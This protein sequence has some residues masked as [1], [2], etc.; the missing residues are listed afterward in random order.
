MLALVPSIEPAMSV[1]RLIFFLS[2]L[3]PL[4]MGGCSAEARVN[5]KI[6]KSAMRPPAKVWLVSNGWHTS[7]AMRTADATKE[8]QAFAPGSKYL[9]IGWGGADFYMWRN[10]HQPL[11]RLRAMIL[12]TTS[13]LHVIPV[14]TSIVE[15]CPNSEVI[16]FEVNEQGLE[17]LRKK[18]HL[19][20]K[21]DPKGRP[22]IAG[23]GKLAASKFFEGTET[24]FFPKTCNLWAAQSLAAAGVPIRV[25]AAIVADNL[26]WQGRKH[27]RILAVRTTVQDP[28]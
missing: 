24:Y 3:V 25:S 16:E 7:V 27:G 23:P 21:R 8:L 19:A 9:V 15:S 4:F 22:A 10:M 28:L 26:C 20:F 2:A 11:R 6:R 1:L 14:K 13:A 17:R 18:L 5:R 12:P